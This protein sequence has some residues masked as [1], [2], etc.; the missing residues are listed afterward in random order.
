MGEH[1]LEVVLALSKVSKMRAPEGARSVVRVGPHGF[2]RRGGDK[3]R[4]VFMGSG[5]AFV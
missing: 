4:C 1:P 2:A 3:A 5:V